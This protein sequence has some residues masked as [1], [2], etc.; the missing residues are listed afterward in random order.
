[1]F[2]LGACFS[3]LLHCYLLY[4][5]GVSFIYLAME[6]KA[7]VFVDYA[8]TLIQMCQRR[9]FLKVLVNSYTPTQRQI[10]TEAICG[11]LGTDTMI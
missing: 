2:Y 4:K 5:E 11:N 7:F 6:T 3:Y 8:H 9:A 10:H 1:M